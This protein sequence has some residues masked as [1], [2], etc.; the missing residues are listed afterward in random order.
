MYIELINYNIERGVV[1][2]GGKDIKEKKNRRRK[3]K[4]DFFI[5]YFGGKK[6]LKILFSLSL[7]TRGG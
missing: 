1:E 3:I 5:F 6:T 4:V 2:L 7:N